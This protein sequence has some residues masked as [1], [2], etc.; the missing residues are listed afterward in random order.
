MEAVQK[1]KMQ[2]INNGNLLEIIDLAHSLRQEHLFIANEQASFNRLNE[3]LSRNSSNV[4]QVNDSF[5]VMKLKLCSK[6]SI[7][8][9]NGLFFVISSSS[10]R[11]KIAVGLDL[12][13][14]T[15]ESKQF[16]NIATRYRPIRM[17]SQGKHT[18]KH[19]IR[20]GAQSQ[21]RKIRSKQTNI[22]IVLHGIDFVA[23]V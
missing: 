9:K 23:A 22:L 13:A 3:T 12:F 8:S 16:D 7:C 14:A 1:P 20:R 17:L 15:T 5:C 19:T 11:T 18:G 10:R 4:A 6:K 21:R 2:D